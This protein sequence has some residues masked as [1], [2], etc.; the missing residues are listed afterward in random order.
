MPHTTLCCRCVPG[1]NGRLRCLLALLGLDMAVLSICLVTVVLGRYVFGGHF[2]PRL[3]LSLAWTPLLYAGIALLTRVYTHLQTPPEAIKKISGALSFFFLVTALFF[4]LTHESATYSR[5]IFL[6]SWGLSLLAVPLTRRAVRSRYPCI[7]AWRAPCVVIGEAE[8]AADM[9]RRIEE[10]PYSGL[11]VVAVSV[12]GATGGDFTVP[13]VPFDK[14]PAL[15]TA[16]PHCYAVLLLDPC[17]LWPPADAMER[18]SFHF[19]HVL[20]RS[21]QLDQISTWTRGVSL[22]GLTLLTCHFKLLDPWRMRFKRAFDIVFCLTAGLAILPFLILLSILIRL[23]SPGPA[24]FTQRRV[25]RGGRHFHIFK[26]RTMRSDAEAYLARLLRENPGLARQWEENQKMMEDP[27]ITKMG[28]WLRA[29]SI[30][31]LPQLINVLLGQM[32]LVGPRPIVDAEVARYGRDYGTYRHVRPGITGLWQIS[33]RNRVDYDQRVL[34]DVAYVRNWSI[35]M[36]LWILGRTVF[37]VL[38]RGGC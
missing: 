38:Q 11:E 1:R 16:N 21:P 32:S 2:S 15:A 22:S 37:E 35:Y 25:G 24:F 7:F 18:L 23:D 5:S 10:N 29:T 31:E 8:A 30:D 28:R 6:M 17:R 4:F 3:Y 33:G 27:R 26:F 12:A 13:V 36:D 34:L 20:L 9:V 19:R 14:L